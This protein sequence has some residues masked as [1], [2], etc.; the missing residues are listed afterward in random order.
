MRSSGSFA[1]FPARITEDSHLHVQK[2]QTSHFQS[3]GE[4]Y[5][6]ILLTTGSVLR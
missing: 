3:D 4:L 6:L 5:F 2:M 1:I